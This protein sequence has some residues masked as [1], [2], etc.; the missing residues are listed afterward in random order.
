MVL[1]AE[2]P[3]GEYVG[4]FFTDSSLSTVYKPAS[5]SAEYINFRLD[6]SNTPNIGALAWSNLS[7]NVGFLS[8]AAGFSSLDG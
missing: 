8:F 6:R 2:T 4:Q 7:A 3:Y 5:D 1:Y